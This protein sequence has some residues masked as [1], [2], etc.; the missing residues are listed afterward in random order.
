MTHKSV[1]TPLNFR[2]G[3]RSTAGRPLPAHLIAEPAPQL[4]KDAARLL[5]TL[6][7]S[8]RSSVEG[9]TMLKFA[10]TQLAKPTRAGIQAVAYLAWSCREAA[11]K[12]HPADAEAEIALGKL[13]QSRSD[14]CN[15]IFDLADASEA[16]LTQ[17]LE[18][19]KA[20]VRQAYEAGFAAGQEELRKQLP[21][22][23]RET[24]FQIDKAGQIV[25]KTERE[26]K[27]GGKS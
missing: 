12:Q 1:S 8:D 18:A 26:F 10:E 22:V 5:E 9:P 11:R 6:P 4:N 21:A 19:S 23:V 13:L 24:A 27:P 17:V 7:R 14:I 16:R 2:E 25:G 3:V 20:V 15:V